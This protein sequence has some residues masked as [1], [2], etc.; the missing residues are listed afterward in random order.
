MP[1]TTRRKFSRR[2]YK[3]KKYVRPAV[4]KYV[5]RQLKKRIERKYINRQFDLT[6]AAVGSV[7]KIMDVA[8]NQGL[9]D[10]QRVGDR[11]RLT[12]I[13]LSYT[14]R[15]L[16]GPNYLRVILFQWKGDDSN[17]TPVVNDII[18]TGAGSNIPII[19]PLKHDHKNG[20][21]FNILY[22]K[23]HSL[24]ANGTD[25]V[26]V[27][28]WLTRGFARDMQFIN[29]TQKGPNQLYMLEI[30]DTGTGVPTGVN[31]HFRVRCNYTDA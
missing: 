15:Q 12:S 28:K 14:L 20:K 10:S 9:S 27:K 7:N 8:P 1:Y 29:G 13:N 6:T 2:G 22:D 23:V 16:G 24:Q 31:F 19:T 4:K 18:S 26:Y 11:I 30:A 25:T 17:Y 5:K 21:H 3:K